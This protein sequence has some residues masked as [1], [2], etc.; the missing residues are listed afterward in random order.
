MGIGNT[1]A[2]A[3]LTLAL[4]GGEAAE[5]TGPGTGVAGPMLAAKREVVAAAAARHRGDA[6]DPFDLLRRLG[7]FEL[8][9]IAG[10]IAA[11][12]QDRKTLAMTS[13]QV[14]AA[15]AIYVAGAAGCIGLGAEFLGPKQ[16]V[17]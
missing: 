11:V 1:T 13:A 9:A 17:A 3:A 4:F 10:W 15:G 14:G 8:A 12:L 16:N 5:W 2:A 6:G 7:G